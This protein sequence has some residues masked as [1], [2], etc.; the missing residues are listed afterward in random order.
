MKNKEI[1]ILSVFIVG[2]ISLIITFSLN[3]NVSDH[4]FTII[5]LSIALSMG[6]S[7]FVSVIMIFDDAHWFW[8]EEKTLISTLTKKFNK[9][10]Y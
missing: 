9:Y 2:M 1:I 8:Y 10:F 5:F 4:I 3:S 7:F 6:L